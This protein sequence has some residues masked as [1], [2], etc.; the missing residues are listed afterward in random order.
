[1]RIFSLKL[2]E[3]GRG[4]GEEDFAQFAKLY[5]QVRQ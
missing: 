3:K 5:W 1:M 2:I 4:P